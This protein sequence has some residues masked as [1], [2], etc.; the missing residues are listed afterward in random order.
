M[1]FDKQFGTIK[2]LEHVVVAIPD[3]TNAL[4]HMTRAVYVSGQGGDLRV[5]MAGG[6]N[7]TLVGLAVGIWHPMMI[8]HVLTGTTATDIRV[9][10]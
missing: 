5:R 10:W 6:E 4:E 2:P 9:G 3:D 1:A 7:V 8:T